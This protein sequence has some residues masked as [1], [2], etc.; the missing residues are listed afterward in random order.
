MGGRDRGGD[1]AN[2][3]FGEGPQGPVEG[4]N[5][6][7]KNRLVGNDIV[8]IARME[9]GH[10]ENEALQRID[11]AR[12]D[13]LERLDDGRAGDDRIARNVGEGG[14]A[15]AAAK[16]HDEFIGR[17]HGRAGTHGEMPDR[18]AGKIVHSIDEGSR[19]AIEKP[20]VDHRLATAA[21]LFGRLEDD[22]DRA[23][24]APRLGEAPRCAQQHGRMPV[25]AAGMHE[26]GA[27]RGIGQAGFLD[28]RESVHIGA[29][30]DDGPAG[31]AA[32][33]DQPDDAGA[34]QARVNL[35]AA[36][37]P[38]LVGDESRR[39]LN[40]VEKLRRLME[41]LAP[42]CEFG[43]ALRDPVVHRHAG[44][45]PL[46]ICVLRFVLRLWFED[47][48]VGFTCLLRLGARCHSCVTP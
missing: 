7:G 44:R 33:M 9:L 41:M 10:R 31:S 4:A 25:M 46:E 21:A 24:K 43:R 35:V 5:R 12:D 19:E 6:A 23:G 37:F 47:R 28:D 2:A 30:A 16:A 20:V 11:I 26:A 14:M 15:A 18:Q 36:E 1:R 22:G 3:L 39:L 13:A 29:K 42:L 27:L 17:G 32:P 38:Q 45:I 8:G 48:R 34:P 40:V